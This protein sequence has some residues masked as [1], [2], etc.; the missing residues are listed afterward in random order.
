[1]SF[2]SLCVLWKYRYSAIETTS[3]AASFHAACRQWA[4]RS[5][6]TELAS[7]SLLTQFGVVLQ[8]WNRRQLGAIIVLEGRCV[9]IHFQALQLIQR[10]KDIAVPQVPLDPLQ[11]LEHARAQL[12]LVFPF[13]ESLRQSL[14]K[15]ASWRNPGR[16]SN[17][18]PCPNAA[19]SLSATSHARY[20]ANLVCRQSK[21][22]NSKTTA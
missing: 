12:V 22:V 16:E 14:A 21:A 3:S 19:P 11:I 10:L 1:M 5:I 4:E 18:V 9:Q 15:S 7:R 13:A 20:P 2:M 17:T 8:L 6:Q